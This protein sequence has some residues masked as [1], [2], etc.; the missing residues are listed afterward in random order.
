MGTNGDIR[1][2]ERVATDFGFKGVQRRDF[3]DFIEECKKNGER[4]S[5]RNGDFTYPELREKAKEY[6]SLK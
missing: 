6:R 1:Q 2:I 4:G 3:G 5:G